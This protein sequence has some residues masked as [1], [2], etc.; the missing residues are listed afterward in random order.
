MLPESE[1][2][3]TSVY[4]LC[5]GSRINSGIKHICLYTEHTGVVTVRV[6][7]VK[8]AE[9]DICTRAVLDGKHYR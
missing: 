5:T 8:Y 3:I 7:G 4:T 6:H 1:Q 9:A 2:N